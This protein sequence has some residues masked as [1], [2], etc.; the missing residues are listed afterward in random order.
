MHIIRHV[1]ATRTRRARTVACFSRACRL[2]APGALVRPFI[3]VDLPLGA[4]AVRA[5]LQRLRQR[6]ADRLPAAQ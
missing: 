4:A 5:R 3:L 6:H 2:P 1:Q